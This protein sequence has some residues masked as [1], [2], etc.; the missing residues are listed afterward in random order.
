MVAMEEKWVD[1]KVNKITGPIIKHLDM[2]LYLS[3]FLF[4]FQKLVFMNI[5]SIAKWHRDGITLILH[6]LIRQN[7][8]ILLKTV[9]F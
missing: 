9:K 3:F 4:S 1:R 5:D 8:L 2:H 6:Y 7:K